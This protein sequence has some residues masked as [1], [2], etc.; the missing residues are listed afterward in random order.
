MTLQFRERRVLFNFFCSFQENRRTETDLESESSEQESAEG[1][2]QNGDVTK[3][4][5]TGPAQ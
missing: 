3:G 2:L 4:N 1:A 5:K